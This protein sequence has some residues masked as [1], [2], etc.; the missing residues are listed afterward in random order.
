[1]TH[2]AVYTRLMSE[3]LA[4]PL[5]TPPTFDEAIAHCPY[6]IACIKE[7]MRLTPAAPNMF[8]R[9]VAQGGLWV[10]GKFVAEGTEMTCNP[11][12]VHRNK[13]LYGE[14]AEA[15]R[16]ERWLENEEKA[17]EWD[18]LDF[19]FGFGS[20]KCLVRRIPMTAIEL[21]LTLDDR[22]KTSRSS[23]CTRG[24]WSSCVASS[25]QLSIRRTRQIT[26]SR[27]ECRGLQTAG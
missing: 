3:I 19:G 15:F 14:D 20:R 7:A 12:I 11:Y 13:A 26:S 24:L 22:D 1:M 5:S 18:I 8:P 25:P 10:E 6:Y 16:P 2:P 21:E 23:S 4:A 9:I 27:E 17:K